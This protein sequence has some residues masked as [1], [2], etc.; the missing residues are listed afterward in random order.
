MNRIRQADEANGTTP[1]QAGA[2]SASERLEFIEL[3][4]KL[5]QV[6]TERDI[7]AKSTAWFANNGD[8]ASTPSMRCAPSPSPRSGEQEVRGHRHQPAVGR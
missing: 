5:R 2:F 1:V 8:K 7:L 6:Q 4:P 3:R